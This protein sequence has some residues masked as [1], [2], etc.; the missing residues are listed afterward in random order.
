MST[1]AAVALAVVSFLIAAG[2]L[3]ALTLVLIRARR[4]LDEPTGADDDRAA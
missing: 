1:F 3:G 4:T 2:A